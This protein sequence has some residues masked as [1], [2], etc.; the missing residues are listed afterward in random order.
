MYDYLKKAN[1]I[2]ARVLVVGFMLFQFLSFQAFGQTPFVLEG[3]IFDVESGEPIIGATIYNR[4]Q[5]VGTSTS[6]KG[7]F[8]ITMTYLPAE[9]EISHVGYEAFSLSVT[10][11]LGKPLSIFL[12]PLSKELPEAVVRSSLPSIKLSQEKEI[13][14]DFDFFSSHVL[15]LKKEAQGQEGKLEMYDK[16]GELIDEMSLDGFKGSMSLHKTCLGSINI[17]HKSK[18]HQLVIEDDILL[19][20]GQSISFQSYNW[21]VLKCQLANE[22]NVYYQLDGY[23]GQLQDYHL[24]NKNRDTNFVFAS[25][26][27]E[28][29]IR[30]LFD[31]VAPLI[32]IDQSTREMT[33]NNA[34]ELRMIRRKQSD[35][36]AK[37]LFFYQPIYCPIFQAGKEVLIFDHQNNLM[38]FYSVDGVFI[39]EKPIDYH[40][41]ENWGRKI[42]KDELSGKFY[43]FFHAKNGKELVEINLQTGKVTEQGFLKCN[44]L[45]EIAVQDGQLYYID[46]AQDDNFDFFIPQLRKVA[47]EKTD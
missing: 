26:Y 33:T 12:S 7:L 9:L 32:A 27:N 17:I 40:L 34:D 13:V 37:K 39:R 44:D 4:F 30:L 1:F 45:V 10:E 23:F 38:L 8:E 16:E 36:D 5:D 20:I 18:V 11:N 3:K 14:L 43:T 41:R 28:H 24:F 42:I 46:S 22:K 31:D 21:E 25:V 35:L 15:V 2:Q 29:Q 47:I 6:L 19:G